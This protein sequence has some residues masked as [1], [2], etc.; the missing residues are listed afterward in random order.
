MERLD[1]SARLLV[2]PRKREKLPKVADQESHH[3]WPL[4]S[5]ANRPQPQ[6]SDI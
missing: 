6:A 5:A 4:V 3:R 2:H 1:T